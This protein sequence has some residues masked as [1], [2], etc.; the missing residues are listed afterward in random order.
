MTGMEQE[1][2]KPKVRGE[3]KGGRNQLMSCLSPSKAKGDQGS[4]PEGLT[5]LL[6]QRIG[7]LNTEF[8]RMKQGRKPTKKQCGVRKRLM[9][10]FRL[11]KLDR[12]RLGT[13][14][15][16]RKRSYVFRRQSSERQRKLPS[17]VE[18]GAKVGWELHQFWK[19]IW[20]SEGTCD[21]KH[22][23]GWRR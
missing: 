15:S 8:Q 16:S 14:W 18:K 12:W 7:W 4:R 3:I 20:G 21:P 5:R 6:R 11:K 9:K 17:G 1:W 19:D 2:P 13:S 10:S 23:S 22:P